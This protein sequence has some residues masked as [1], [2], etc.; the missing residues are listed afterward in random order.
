MN[1]R[2]LFNRCGSSSR[3]FLRA[4]SKISHVSEGLLDG[5]KNLERADFRYNLC[6]NKAAS[7]FSQVP[8]LIEALKLNCSDIEPETTTTT[9]TTFQPPK[10]EISNFEKFVCE[11]EDEIEILRRS[12]WSAW[13]FKTKCEARKPSWDLEELKLDCKKSKDFLST[14]FRSLALAKTYLKIILIKIYW[15]FWNFV[16]F[17]FIEFFLFKISNKWNSFQGHFTRSID[18]AF[19]RTCSHHIA[20]WFYLGLCQKIPSNSI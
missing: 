9:S 11:L 18:V 2:L 8:A 12:S 16:N 15:L 6:I 13:G 1:V 19:F 4:S 7:N 3:K 10:Y 17:L 5:L 14:W 20:P